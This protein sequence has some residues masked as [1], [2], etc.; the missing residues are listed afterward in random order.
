M[1]T[2]AYQKKYRQFF[3]DLSRSPEVK[4]KP[5]TI[6]G[7]NFTSV[8][9]EE[10]LRFFKKRMGI[11]ES[12][13]FDALQNEWYAYIEKLQASGLRGYEEAGKKAFGNGEWMFRAPRLLKLAIEKGSKDPDTF[14]GLSRCLRMKPEG[15]AEALE[16]VK[17]GCEI[18]PLSADCWAE[19]GYVTQLMGQK[20]EGKK[21]VDL[22]YE[23]D[24]AGYFVDYQTLLAAAGTK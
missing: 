5:V 3:V 9:N 18:D 14:I 24:P 17:K 8:E 4:R 7:S 15:L 13:G 2:P 10:V 22:A 11:S 19:R 23:L 20:D 6:A 21:L 12:G 16:V 1:E